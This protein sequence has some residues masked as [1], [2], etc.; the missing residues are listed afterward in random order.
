MTSADKTTSHSIGWLFCLFLLC[1][2]L[3]VGCGDESDV[4]HLTG[5]TMGTSWNITYQPAPGGHSEEQLSQRVSGVLK[6]IDSSMSTYRQSSEISRFN[7]EQPGQWFSVS[8]SFLDVL[9]AALV[10]G[11]GSSGAYDVTVGPL[12]NR[13]GFGPGHKVADIPSKEETQELLEGVGQ[14]MLQVDRPGLRILKSSG[15][16]LDF[17]SIAKGYAVDQVADFLES[18][19]IDDFLVEVGGEIRVSGR[20]GRGDLWRIA[21][22]QPDGTRG[23]ARAVEL[24][25]LAV[26]TS[27]D[28]RNYFEQD[29]KRY[30]HSIDPRTGHPIEHD[31]VSV[32][33]IHASAMMA[34]AWATAL[35]VLGGDHAM[36]LAQ[37]QQMAV[38]FIRRVEDSFVESHSDAFASYLQK[39]KDRE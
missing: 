35:T 17:S 20:S 6:E 19:Q 12:V 2:V 22:E 37:E 13:W 14:N 11:K 8:A 16:S 9:E 7:R 26:A 27:G 30:S 1:A 3:L 28:Y 25:D 18:Q 38:Y 39:A 5:R 21:I 10:V 33:V 24:T 34:D 36:E 29:G 4:S 23:V 15:L 32:T 31:L